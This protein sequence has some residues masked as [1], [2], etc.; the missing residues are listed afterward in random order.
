M[1]TT[2]DYSERVYAGVL[3]KVIGVYTGK[4]FEGWTHES[5][6]E[7]LG[8][9]KGYVHGSEK[10]KQAY[11]R[12]GQSLPLGKY[13][14]ISVD[15]DITGTFTFIRALA[16]HGVS[17]DITAEQIGNSWLNYIIEEKSILWWGG[18]GNSTEHTAF[19]RLKQGIP[20][21]QSGSM[22][23]NS[24][25]VAEQIGSQIFID[26]WAMVAPGN[27]ELACRM[28]E[29]AASVSHDGEAVN[30][31]KIVAGMEALAFV[32]SDIS[33]ILDESVRFIPTDSLIYRLIND[34]REWH[35][36]GPD[37]QT[38][39]GKIQGLYGYD[40]Y[41]GNCHMVPNHGLIIH[42][43]LHAEDN[44]SEAL[45]IV[46]TSGWDTDCNSGNVGC[47]MGI[48]LGL[49]GIDASL[50]QGVDWRGPV[51]DQMYMPTAEGGRV[52]TDCVTEAVE[53]IRLGKTLAGENYCYPKD[54][55]QFHFEFPGSVQGFQLDSAES[56]TQCKVFNAKGHSRHGTRSLCVKKDKGICVISSPVFT[57]SLE[58]AE[59][60][61]GHGYSLMA[62]PRLYSGQMLR[63]GLQTAAS[64]PG[65]IE[66]SLAYQYYGDSDQQSWIKGTPKTVHPG[67]YAFLELQVGSHDS[68]PVSHIGWFLEGEG[69]VVFFDYLRWDGEP[70]VVWTRP[71]GGGVMWTHA[72]INALD[73]P[74]SK[75][76]LLFPKDE[77][78]RLVQNAGTGMLI[79]GTREWRNY[80]VVADVTPHAVQAAGI[81]ARVQGLRR[82]YSLQLLKPQK[83]QLCKMLDSSTVL[84]EINFS[85]ELGHTYLL[86]LEVN[87][88][89]LKARVD[90]QLILRAEDSD[91][92]LK[93]GG[94]ALLVSEGRTATQKVAVNGVL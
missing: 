38:T 16:D 74:L 68:Q 47:F 26:G 8:E 67:E 65:R 75:S 20:G 58:I 15:D 72:W 41:G 2:P 7:E 49:E 42:A 82:Y 11:A 76:N 25:V 9:I 51:A 36:A 23:L 94:I 61:K 30:G 54:G 53:L 63:S 52:I 12:R 79:Q 70:H 17:R 40:R 66:V 55:A 14:L 4:P 69:S 6:M 27:P 31:A 43:I 21:P 13:P 3:G 48:K 80:C 24:K 44:F 35:A 71:E 73:L 10:L 89:I 1:Q 62:V 32:E 45:K 19:L 22:E 64:N 93:D 60:F 37:W 91:A 88:N 5:I 50:K 77:T 87:Q 59:H 29:Q 28:A 83:L 18:M 34:I 90:G 86:E 56:N 39:L 78:F 46:N 81:A 84:A 85:W 92:S 57:P 33:R